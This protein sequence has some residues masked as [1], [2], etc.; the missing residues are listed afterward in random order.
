VSVE[1]NSLESALLKD[2]SGIEDLSIA[3]GTVRLLAPSED[4]NAVIDLTKVSMLA[5]YDRGLI[6]FFRAPRATGYQQDL[7]LIDAL[8][9]SAVEAEFD[10]D[11]DPAFVPDEEDFVFF[12]ATEAGRELLESLPAETSPSPLGR[13]G[14]R[15]E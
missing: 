14:D 3:Y 10:S 1:L 7:Q 13:L 8:T 12:I 4:R 9:R 2:A 15:S 11:L 5:L 6:V